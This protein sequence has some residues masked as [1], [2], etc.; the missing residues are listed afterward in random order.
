MI[1]WSTAFEQHPAIRSAYGTDTVK[2]LERISRRQQGFW[3]DV[4]LFMFEFLRKGNTTVREYMATFDTFKDESTVDYDVKETPT[5]VSALLH[6]YQ[7]DDRCIGNFAD[8]DMFENS[9]VDTW[10]S[11]DFQTYFKKKHTK[12]SWGIPKTAKDVREKLEQIDQM[13][14]Q[15]MANYM[16]NSSPDCKRGYAICVVHIGNETFNTSLEPALNRM[17][18]KIRVGDAFFKVIYIF[19]CQKHD[20][21]LI[22]AL[23]RRTITTYY[24]ATPIASRESELPSQRQVNMYYENQLSL[25]ERAL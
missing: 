6:A 12:A 24:V 5:F 22:A 13:S 7:K 19:I 14:A 17:P 18:H 20:G 21:P 3:G 25:I 1:A 15:A 23:N 2:Q 11:T 4:K 8:V 16:Y 10:L 9:I